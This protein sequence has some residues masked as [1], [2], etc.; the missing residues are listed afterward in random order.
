MST[1]KN[2]EKF[3]L[4]TAVHAD[5]PAIGKLYAETVR[6]VNNADYSPEQIK[7]WSASGYEAERWEKR[8]AEQYFILAEINGKLAGFG[9]VDPSGYLD[10]MYVS[11]DHQRMGVAKAIL[12]EIE[13]KAAEQNNPQIYSHVSK[14]AFG[15][16]KKH[17]YKKVRELNDPYKGVVFTNNLMV[18]NY[19]GSDYSPDIK[20]ERL[21]L[22]RYTDADRAESVRLSLDKEVMHFMG[23]EHAENEEQ[24]NIIFD[25]CFEIYKG[26]LGEDPLGTRRFE[27]WGIEHG[28][29]LIGHFELK[30]SVNTTGNE[31]EIVYLLDKNYWGK[32]L[33][34]EAISAVNDYAKR[35]GNFV[36]ATI[37]PNNK[38]TVRSLE[39]SGI[40]KQEWVEDSEGKVYKIWLK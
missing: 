29:K 14:T 22:R 27:L 36:I 26:W 8:I 19:I 2:T 11:K 9:S 23:G 21:L 20:T 30:Q 39:K 38:R 3:K 40:A 13:R 10:F 35:S 7:I 12:D 28:R 33:I 1:S 18:K 37:D 34:P 15:F 5:I 25:K 4:R 24:A 6:N 16:F 17:G 32:G 31:L